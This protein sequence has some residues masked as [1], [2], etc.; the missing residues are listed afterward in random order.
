MEA[1]PTDYVRL[2]PEDAY[3]QLE[4]HPAWVVERSRI[5]RDYRFPSFRDAVAFVVQVADL[6]EA[7]AHHP[8]ILIHEWSFVR[9]ELYSHLI[10]GLTQADVDFAVAV[11]AL[12]A[13]QAP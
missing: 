8:N 13:G 3:R 9:L 6:A 11:D 2:T 4:G 5:Y 7:A 10:D 1:T 12:S